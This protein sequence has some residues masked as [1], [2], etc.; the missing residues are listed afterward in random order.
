MRGSWCSMLLAL[1]MALPV[2]SSMPSALRNERLRETLVQSL[3]DNCVVGPEGFGFICLVDMLG[4]PLIVEAALDGVCDAAPSVRFAVE[5]QA[6]KVSKLADVSAES[7]RS[8][9][10]RLASGNLTAG[11]NATHPMVEGCYDIRLHQCD[12]DIPDQASCEALNEPGDQ[13]F[14]WTP[15]CTSC[16][17]VDSWCGIIRL[18]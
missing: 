1:P 12:C 3:P 14:F 7:R 2:C 4:E 6:T 10:T 17:P 5:R 15:G 8:L 11:S 18:L 9:S 13:R 16:A